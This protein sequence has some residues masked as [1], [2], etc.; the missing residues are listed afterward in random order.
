MAAGL[1]GAYYLYIGITL[2]A[3]GLLS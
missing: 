3:G 2:L 1:I